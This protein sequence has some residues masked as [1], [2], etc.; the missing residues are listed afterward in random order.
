[1]ITGFIDDAIFSC[2][3]LD[4]SYDELTSKIWDIC[5]NFEDLQYNEKCMA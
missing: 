1:M 4:Y 5:C 3:A 2:Y